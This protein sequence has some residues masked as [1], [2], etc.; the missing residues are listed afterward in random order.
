MAYCL[1]QNNRFPDASWRM[2]V[3]NDSR[4]LTLLF[5][6]DVDAE[7]GFR[8]LKGVIR[9]FAAKADRLEQKIADD[10]VL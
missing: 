10:D 7:L 3:D 9:Y 8:G 1:E 2:R 6:I 4:V 5:G